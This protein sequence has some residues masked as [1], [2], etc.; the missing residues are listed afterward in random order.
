MRAA[1][2]VSYDLLRPTQNYE[3]V[4]EVIKNCPGWARLGGSAYIVLSDSS[5]AE[6]R[7]SIRSAMDSN[8]KLFVGVIKAPAAWVGLGDEVSQWLKNNLKI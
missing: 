3:K 8:D 7:D 4:L 2:I 6:L 5:A 1:Y